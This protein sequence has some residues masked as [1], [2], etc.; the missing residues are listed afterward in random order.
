MP[1][2][3]IDDLPQEFVTP[4]HSKAFG[5]LVTGEHVEVGI[6]EF[7]AGEGAH[8]HSHPHEQIVVVLKGK[9]RFTVDGETF[10]VGPGQAVHIPP[11]VHHKGETLEDS[12]VISVKS[13]VGGVGHKI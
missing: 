10:E 7:K 12:L 2:I 8:E 3:N 11:N 9:S 5:R 6:L 4:K 1:L 13:I